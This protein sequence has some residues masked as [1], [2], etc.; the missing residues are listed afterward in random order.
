MTGENDEPSSSIERQAWRAE[1][2]CAEHP[3]GGKIRIRWLCPRTR[4][5]KGEILCQ[6]VR[7][8][9]W[10]DVQCV[11][12]RL[13]NPKRVIGL[14]SLPHEPGVFRFMARYYVGPQ[15]VHAKYKGRVLTRK[16]NPDG[17]RRKPNAR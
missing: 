15:I 4:S 1:R 6:I 13:I 16:E 9:A 17:R 8:S 3:V 2:A 12:V 5:T 10:F 7:H 11:D 14:R